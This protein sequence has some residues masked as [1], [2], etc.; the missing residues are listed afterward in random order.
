M[1]QKNVPPWKVEKLLNPGLCQVH[2]TSVEDLHS[3][4]RSMLPLMKR[5]NFQSQ[6]VSLL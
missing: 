3:K 1:N 4:T 5:A 6:L 2:A